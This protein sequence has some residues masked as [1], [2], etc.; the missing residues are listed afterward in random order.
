MIPAPTNNYTDYRDCLRE[1]VAQQ[2]EEWTFK[3]DPRYQRVLEHVDHYQGV[4]FIVQIKQEYAAYWSRA[5]SILPA[6][7]EEN[8]RYGKPITDTFQEIGLTCSPSNLRY[9]SQALR[10]WTHALEMGMERM[11]VV[12]LGGGYGGLALYVHRLASLFPSVE[13]AWYTIVDLPE[14]ADI[15][16]MVFAEWGVP[17]MTVNGLDE[18]ALEW[19]LDHADETQAPRFLFSAYA[20]SEFDE[21]TRDYYAERVAKHCEHGVLIWNFTNGPHEKLAERPVGGPV[22]QFIN[23][24]LRTNLDQPAMYPEPIQLVRF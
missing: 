6:I 3:S 11:H 7:V 2:P 15:Q 20:F 23:K 9:L 19:C 14:A 10:L 22:Y 24:P 13:L 4:R 1:A 18:V 12:E 8:D 16:E 5:L 17:A 21:E